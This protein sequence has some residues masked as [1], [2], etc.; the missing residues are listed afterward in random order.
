MDYVTI[1]FD[2]IYPL[3]LGIKMQIGEQLVPTTNFQEIYNRASLVAEK[4]QLIL[5]A[6]FSICH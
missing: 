5:I 2:Q 3:N 1:H 6:I 4:W